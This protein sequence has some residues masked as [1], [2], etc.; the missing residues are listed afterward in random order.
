[1]SQPRCI[2]THGKLL[3]NFWGVVYTIRF[4]CQS[5][6]ILLPLM[7][8]KV[9][10]DRSAERF[11]RLAKKKGIKMY[12]ESFMAFIQ[13]PESGLHQITRNYWSCP[14]GPKDPIMSSFK[15]SKLQGG[16]GQRYQP[17]TIC[18]QATISPKI[19]SRARATWKHAQPNCNGSRHFGNPKKTWGSFELVTGTPE[20][21]IPKND[22]H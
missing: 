21:G 3:N 19:D 15:T 18:C 7:C 11:R 8:D 14:Q 2:N 5:N 20:T 9:Y 12:R 10:I 16:V 1:M 4:D 13:K 6:W 17:S 22:P